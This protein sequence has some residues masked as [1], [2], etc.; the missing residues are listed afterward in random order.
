MGINRDRDD[1]ADGLD[2]CPAVANNG[3][4]DVDGDGIGDACD[5]CLL[6]AN[7]DQTDADRDGVG[8]ACLFCAVQVDKDSYVDGET[9]TLDELRWANLGA[10]PTPTRLRLQITVVSFSATFDLIDA[11]NDGSIVLPAGLNFVTGPAPL[12]PITAALPRGDWQLRRAIEEPGTGILRD[13]SVT[14]FEL[15]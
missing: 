3:Q 15:Q 8:D 11:G 12:L 10:L 6:A 7:P 4:A 2:N 13:E 9:V 14:T 1:F 5:N